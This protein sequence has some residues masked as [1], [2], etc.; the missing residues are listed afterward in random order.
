[1]STKRN[2]I[3]EHISRKDSGYKITTIT[4]YIKSSGYKISIC[5]MTTKK[6][7]LDALEIHAYIKPKLSV[8]NF[9]RG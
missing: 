3:F 1:L 2:E 7:E 6:T 4:N 8:S 5:Y 9:K